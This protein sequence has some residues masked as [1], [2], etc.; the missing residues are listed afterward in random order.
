MSGLPQWLCGKES[1]CNAGTSGD[2]SWILGLGR[3]SGGGHGNLFWPEESHGQ[4][5][6]VGFSPQG[7]KESDTTE[8]I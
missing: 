5:S 1:T 6:L 2:M 7:R 3:P 4:R 8:V